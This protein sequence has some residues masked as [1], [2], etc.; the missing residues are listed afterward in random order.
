M[1]TLAWKGRKLT[2]ITSRTKRNADF[3]ALLE[4]LDQ[5]AFNRNRLKAEKL[6]GSRVLE[7]RPIGR[8]LL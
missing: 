2:V 3:I 4:K 7:L 6:I 5:P 1:G 8:R